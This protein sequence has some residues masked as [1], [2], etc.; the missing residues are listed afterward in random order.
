MEDEGGRRTK[1]GEQRTKDKHW[2]SMVEIRDE[3]YVPW[4][5]VKSIQ[6]FCGP[7]AR[8][9]YNGNTISS[10]STD[11]NVM[12][13]FFGPLARRQCNGNTISIFSTN[14]NE[15]P[16]HLLFLFFYTN[17]MAIQFLFNTGPATGHIAHLWCS[18]V[19]AVHS[20]QCAVCTLCT[21]PAGSTS[22]SMAV[23]SSRFSASSSGTNIPA[24]PAQI[25]P[26][27][28]HKYTRISGTNITCS[29]ST[30]PAAG[31]QGSAP[32]LHTK[33]PHQDSTPPG[34]QGAWQYAGVWH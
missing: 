26:Q 20:V 7:L 23:L 32:R 30:N 16:I 25:Y 1:D 19:T 34:H 33:T 31:H 10:F 3:R 12:A 5:G 18:A 13:I 22:R 29:F 27:L 17:V 21:L 15:T 2:V 14:G 11:S 4:P 24:A 9:Q 6:F 28:R 8:H